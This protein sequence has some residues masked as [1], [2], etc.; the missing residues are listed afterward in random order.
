MVAIAMACGVLAP[1]AWATA[2][3][4]WTTGTAGTESW[5]LGMEDETSPSITSLS[6][7]SYEIAFQANTGHL[8]T[9]GAD[10]WT[11]WDLGLNRTSSPS[12][13]GTPG[14]GFEAAF[15]GYGTTNVLWDAGTADTADSN[16]S[17]LPGTSPSIAALTSDSYEIAYVASNDQL[18]ELG[19][20]GIRVNDLGLWP[21]TSPSITRLSNGSYEIAFEAYGSGDLWLYGSAATENTG[22]VMAPGTSPAIAGLTNGSYE[23]AYHGTNGDGW[24]YTPTT[25]VDDLGVP[26]MSGSDPSIA[27]LSG[28]GA[29]VA[30]QAS[31][32]WLWEI[33]P[34]GDTNTRLGLNPTTSPSVAALP[35]NG[36]E[37]AFQSYAG[38]PPS[39]GTTGIQP[40]PTKPSGNKHR[41]R[42]RVLTKVSLRWL[43]H[44][45]V[46]ELV[47]MRFSRLP[48]RAK[49]AVS[50]T[51]N[52][53]P[54]S[55]RTA[56]AK[57]IGSLRRTLLGSRFHAG[58]KVLIVISAPGERPEH[59]EFAIRNGRKPSARLL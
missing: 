38:P 57:R 43:W 47:A 22:I 24:T 35:G 21:G 14:N 40:E 39:T 18:A 10:G 55:R 46:T 17:M 4:L 44:G 16:L 8:W 53:C 3:G 7:G 9:I 42:R 59:A 32:R 26:M 54:R 31:N 52:G 28:G 58:D 11:S 1:S 6:N 36:Y 29:E 30:V 13:A 56:D 5:G 19:S 34:S 20:D 12:I 33:G 25:G 37:V 23:V 2:G 48:R 50:C 15:S 45:P 51:G 49:I 41:K 27:G